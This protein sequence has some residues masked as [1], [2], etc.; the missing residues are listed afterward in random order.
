M[1]RRRCRSRSQSSS[2]TSSRVEIVAVNQCSGN[3]RGFV[4]PRV[5]GGQFGHG[6][7]GNARWRGVALKTLLE[8]AGPKP[9]AQSVAF[10][11]LDSPVAPE[12]PDFVKALDLGHAG[13]GEVMLAYA[14]N[15]EDLPWLNG[16]PLRLVVPGCYG[17]YWVKHLND[18]EVLDSDFS[19]FWMSSAYRI[20]D[21]DC[22]CVTPGAP[23]GATRPI[24][25]LNVRSFVTRP[26]EDAKVAAHV[27]FEVRGIAFDGGHGHRSRAALSRRRR[28]LDRGS[29]WRGSRPLFL[30]RM[31]D[32]TV[33]AARRASFEIPRRQSRRPVAALGAL[34]EPRRLYAER[35]G[36]DSDR[37][38]L[39]KTCRAFAKR[40]S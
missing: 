21:N 10:N 9:G 25:R 18:I 28:E 11:G 1:S 6:A 32:R 16:F 31:A 30:P 15:G 14:M 27:A 26:A 5:G 4:E 23:K 36:D 40:S 38:G 8:K 17:T 13:D 35:G 20:P 12:T 29:A 19:G 34:M 24:K 2:A 39:T 7:M 3:S 33:A 22:V 37:G